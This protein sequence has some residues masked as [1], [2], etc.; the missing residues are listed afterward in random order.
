MVTPF[1]A[2]ENLPRRQTEPDQEG[3]G[4]DYYLIRNSSQGFVSRRFL[5]DFGANI[6]ATNLVE[7]VENDPLRLLTHLPQ[8]HPAFSFSYFKNLR[9]LVPPGG[10]SIVGGKSLK[11]PR[12]NSPSFQQS[13]R[14]NAIIKEFF[15]SLPQ[16]LGG[17]QGIQNTLA[18]TAMVTAQT[19]I[20]AVP[21][22]DGEG[23]ACI[24]PVDSLTIKFKRPDR[25]SSLVPYQM[26]RNAG[27]KTEV[28]LN[29]NTVFWNTMDAWVDDAHG[30]IMYAASLSEMVFD[31]AMYK[32]VRDSIHANGHPRKAIPFNFKNAHEIATKIHML[33]LEEAKN[34]VIDQFTAILEA[35]KN[36]M[37]DQDIVYDSEGGQIVL[38]TPGSMDGLAKILEIM[39]RR[40]FWSMKEFASMMGITQG[41]ADY[42]TIEW[43]LSSHVIETLR[44]MIVEPLVRAINLHF[45]L[46]GE[47]FVAQ[48]SYPKMRSV[49]LLNEQQ[50][51]RLKI[52]NQDDLYSL[53]LID[54]EEM[55]IELTGSGPVGP[56][57]PPNWERK[58]TNEGEDVAS[59]PDGI[60][61]E[62]QQRQNEDNNTK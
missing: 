3:I 23:L 38:L 34:F 26:Q 10:L 14:A 8:L 48:P 11:R 53:G 61:K 27:K 47:N 41:N 39:E 55:S 29:I 24:W 7:W 44:S 36:Q 52:K 18:Q 33:N 5:H 62:E 9:L 20:E 59:N 57:P 56:K 4:S 45:R 43:I 16:E 21:R 60:N 49:D 6:S 25:N 51:L 50:V 31:I 42:T 28:P 35:L 46:M 32:D 15:D 2:I 22:E 37:P 12:K 58:Q 13:D 30:T 19:F 54:H 17:L 1:A 40:L